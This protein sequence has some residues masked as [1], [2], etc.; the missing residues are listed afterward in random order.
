MDYNLVLHLR[1]ELRK[2]KINIWV[3][4]RVKK[5]LMYVIYLTKKPQRGK[6]TVTQIYLL[7]KE[8]KNDKNLKMD[9]LGFNALIQDSICAHISFWNS[10]S[11]KPITT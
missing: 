1:A 4:Y 8:I 5:S 2:F 6:K 11:P 9:L 7:R 3:L 10:S